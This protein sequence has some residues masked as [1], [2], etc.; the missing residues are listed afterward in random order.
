MATLRSVPVVLS[1]AGWLCGCAPDAI[2]APPGIVPFTPPVR[3]R[4]YWALTEACSAH[5]GDFDAVRW[6]IVPT[7]RGS[8]DLDGEAVGA[9]WYG[10]GNQ[11]VFAEG[12]EQSSGLVR[13]EML[14][15]HGISP[16]DYDATG[17]AC[18]AG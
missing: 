9:A 15:A 12:Q 18:R 10:A 4:M 14:L 2:G 8:F 1:L 11:I 7:P 13:H 6:F 3:F 17:A 5:T 16:G